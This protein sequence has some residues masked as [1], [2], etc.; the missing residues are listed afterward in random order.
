MRRILPLLAWPTEEL[1]EILLEIYRHQPKKA[2]KIHLPA[3][4]QNVESV[5]LVSILLRLKP[6]WENCPVGTKRSFHKSLIGRVLKTR[7]NN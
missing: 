6:I 1:V 3:E 2:E 5:C 4:T 7:H